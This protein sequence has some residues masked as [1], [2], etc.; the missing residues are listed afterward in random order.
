[1]NHEPVFDHDRLD[2]NRLS[3][4][5]VAQSFVFAEPKSSYDSGVDYEHEYHDAEYEYDEHE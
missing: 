3:I 5:Y 1:M 4:A 2:V